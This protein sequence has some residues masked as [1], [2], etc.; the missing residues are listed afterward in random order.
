V[1]PSQLGAE[2]DHLHKRYTLLSGVVQPLTKLSL[3]SPQLCASFH[4][5]G[6]PSDQSSTDAQLSDSQ[7]LMND[8]DRSRRVEV[9]SIAWSKQSV[10]VPSSCASPSDSFCSLPDLPSLHKCTLSCMRSLASMDSILPIHCV[11]HGGLRMPQSI[12]ETITASFI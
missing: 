2:F 12:P 4:G 5:S 9:F 8:T 7:D 1:L 11:R 3:N 6:C 10:F